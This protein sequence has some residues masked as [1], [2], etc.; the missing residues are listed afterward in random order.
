MK[1]FDFLRPT[2][3][4][5]E[6]AKNFCRRFLNIIDGKGQTEVLFH[7]AN[8]K[9]RLGIAKFMAVAYRCVGI[10]ANQMN[11]LSVVTRGQTS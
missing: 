2:E 8:L 10:F 7:L 3:G 9:I 5:K 1:K 4:S 6:F 11:F